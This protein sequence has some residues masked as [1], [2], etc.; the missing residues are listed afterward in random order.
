MGDAQNLGKRARHVHA[1]SAQCKTDDPLS[2]IDD[3]LGKN[4]TVGP[5]PTN[6]ERKKLELKE[7]IK[8][9]MAAMPT[10]FTVHH[11][12]GDVLRVL[13]VAPKVLKCRGDHQRA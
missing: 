6:R 11:L 10:R 3:D 9:V 7:L 13:G 2:A 5:G 1:L 12:F 4:T 8:H